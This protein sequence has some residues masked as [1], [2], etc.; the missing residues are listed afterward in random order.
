MSLCKVNITQ[1]LTARIDKRKDGPSMHRR[2]V[3][4]PELWA[5]MG[6]LK[7]EGGRLGSSMAGVARDWASFCGG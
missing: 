5:C 6:F 7:G 2:Q 1:I 4:Q 3:A